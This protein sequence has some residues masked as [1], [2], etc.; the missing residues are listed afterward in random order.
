M[1]DILNSN[2]SDE[3]QFVVSEQFDGYRLDKFIS[4]HIAQ[5]SRNQI[6][7]LIQDGKVTVDEVCILSTKKKVFTGQ[8]I[9]V[10]DIPQAPET[11]IEPVKVELNILYQDTN[12][13]VINKPAGL[14]THPSAGHWDSSLQQG[15]A[16][17]FNQVLELPRW[18]MIHRLDKDTTGAIVFALNNESLMHLQSMLAKHELKRTYTAAVKG[19]PL[20]G[21]TIDLP[22]GRHRTDRK[23]MA[24]VPGGRRS[25]TH[26]TVRQKYTHHAQLEI[27]LATGRTHQIRVHL[28]SIGFPVLGDTMYGG[29]QQPIKGV[30][31]EFIEKIVAFKRQAL[32]AESLQIPT[33]DSKEFIVVTAPLPHD[34]SQLLLD[35]EHQRH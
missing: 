34:M 12:F 6:Q 9:Q 4:D 3:L 35:L 30:E 25:I 10:L 14:V 17:Q 2:E 29:I 21:K 19:V 32:H 8:T 5:W 26:F 27:V 15:V 1:E 18:G 20:T 28:S 11:Q 7:K 23:Q 24:V 13:L 22:I 33:M 16:W 31:A